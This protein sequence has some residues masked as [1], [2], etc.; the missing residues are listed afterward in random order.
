M[1]TRFFD[2]KGGSIEIDNTDISKV[3]LYSLRSQLGVVPQD[4]LLFDGSIQENISLTR[5]EASFEEIQT[6]AQVACAD[7]FIQDLPS[8]YSTKVGERGSNLSGG[9]RQ[10]I[11]IARMVLKQPK[12][13]ILDEATSSLDIDT[14][15]QVTNAL[16]NLFKNRTVLFITHRLTNLV[17]ADKILVLHKGILVEQGTHEELI[18]INGRYATL[19]RQQKSGI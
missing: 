11:A 1:L 4:S 5:P 19:F 6:A 3:D 7:S 17:H 2:P 13:L 12:M 15:Y 8:G 16:A 9:Q 18:K 10:R 14:E